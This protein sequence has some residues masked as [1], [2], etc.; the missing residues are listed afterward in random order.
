M[1]HALVIED[2]YIIA[3]LI[4][5][6]IMEAG[7][8]TVALAATQAEAIAAA[9][10]RNPA[11]ILS[12]VNLAEG[13][14]PGAVQIILSTLGVIPVVFVTGSPNECDPRIKAAA[15]FTKPFEPQ[16]LIREVE[17]IVRALD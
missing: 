10:E 5:D 1:C 16:L 3:T 17:Q 8:T 14:G 9:F 15:I 13:T 12:D 2:N 11:I 7:V 6:M 4:A